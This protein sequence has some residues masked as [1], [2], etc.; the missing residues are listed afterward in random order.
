MDVHAKHESVR[1]EPVEGRMFYANPPVY[2]STG[3]GWSGCVG[4]GWTGCWCRM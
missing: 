3:S 2:P 1:P 4:A